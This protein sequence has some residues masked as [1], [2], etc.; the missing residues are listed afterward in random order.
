MPLSGAVLIHS[1]H[2]QHSYAMRR[3]SQRILATAIIILGFVTQLHA[4]R[5]RNYIYLFD[6]TQSMQQMGL[7]DPARTAL[8]KT[9]ERQRNQDGCRFTVIPFQAKAYAPITFDGAEYPKMKKEIGQAFDSY[10]QNLTNT[11]IID[12]FHAGMH[13]CD[14][15]MD[16]RVYL[17]T[18]GLPTVPGETLDAVCRE[19]MKWCDN[20]KNTRFFYVT[21]DGVASHP[22]LDE[23][24]NHCNDAFGVKCNG[25]VIPQISDIDDLIYAN[26]LEL[27]KIY[28]KSFSEPGTYPI[29]V[30]CN[31]PYFDVEIMGGK[32]TAQTIDFKFH[33]RGNLS[34]EELNEKLAQL[35][36]DSGNYRFSFDLSSTDK[37]MTIANPTVT[38]IMT[39]RPQRILNINDGSLDEA[40][41]PGSSWYPS[42]LWSD[43]KKQEMV[44]YNLNPHFNN[45]SGAKTAMTFSVE[46]NDGNDDDYTVYF[47]GN[48]MGND[49]K[50][51]VTPGEKAEVGI[52]FDKDAKTGKRY[53][54]LSNEGFSELEIINGIPANEVDEIPFRTRYDID[55]NPLAT[56]FFWIG[57]AICSLLILWFL[58]LKRV[59]FPTFNVPSIE[60][61][62]PDTYYKS[63]KIRG[64]RAV[65]L[66]N[67]TKSQN[68]LSRIFTGKIIYIKG[69]HWT[70]E[71]DIIPGSRKN[72]R[73]IRSNAWTIIPSSTVGRYETAKIVNGDIQSTLNVN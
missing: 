16:N 26:T 19:I 22:K 10:I 59:F 29:T 32:V 40:V 66:V 3:S 1:Y 24:L 36:D 28:R 33:I 68:F 21:L 50:F 63:C 70:P 2:S 27:D 47:N 49:G 46:S 57:V 53:F 54:T 58:I 8:D 44:T 73:F 72:I 15:M 13:A 45:A 43:E 67:K 34:L 65:R 39:N 17:L 42:F 62:G 52:L 11:S 20:H 56:V 5:Q 60:F 35:T 38:V 12:V 18:D 31:D 51:T 64:A 48:P 61:N 25:G 71:L 55:W 69:D 23:A 6:C 7:W 41:I 37:D 30:N 9:I 4:Q 14:P